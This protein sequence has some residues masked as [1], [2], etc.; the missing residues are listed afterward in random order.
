MSSTAHSDGNMA[1]LAPVSVI[2]PCFRCKDTIDRAIQSIAD[3]SL[4]PAEII[5]VDDFSPDDSLETLEQIAARYPTDWIRIISLPENVGAASARNRGWDAA[6]QPLIAFLDDDD[7]WHP[8]KIEIQYEHMR[9]H[10]ALAL[11]AHESVRLATGQGHAEGNP[12]SQSFTPRSITRNALLL[13]NRFITPSVM[14]RR[15]IPSGSWRGDGTWKTTCS[16]C[17]SPAVG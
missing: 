4:R 1:P 11:S 2:V 3:Q 9:R 16:G 12:L 6:S 5:L 7:A 8:L 14:L 13:S 10:P 17:E 15:D